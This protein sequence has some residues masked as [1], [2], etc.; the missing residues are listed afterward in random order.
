MDNVDHEPAW[1]L[2]ATDDELFENIGRELLG[3]GLGVGGMDPAAWRRFGKDW[4]EANITKLQNVVCSN[5]LVRTSVTEAP[6]D[7][8][9]I[10]LLLMP[11]L[12]AQQLALA[13]AA[14]ILRSGVVLF[15][16]TWD[17]GHRLPLR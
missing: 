2:G 15:C 1:F 17:D 5:D 9:G 6:Q 7:L 16:S 14:I 8:A 10:A 11:L 4:Y 13:V 12:A 3:E